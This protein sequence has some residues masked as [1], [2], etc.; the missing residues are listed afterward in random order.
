MSP[1]V[2]GSCASPPSVLNLGR[3]FFAPGVGF[4][5]SVVPAPPPLPPP[6]PPLSEGVVLCLPPPPVGVVGVVGELPE[7]PPV[8]LPLWSPLLR[9]VIGML[10][11]EP[12]AGPFVY[13]A[14]G[15]AL[16]PGAPGILSPVP[17]PPTGGGLSPTVRPL[18]GWTAPL[19]PGDRGASPPPTTSN[20]ESEASPPGAGGVL[21]AGEVLLPGDGLL[22]GKGTFPEV[23]ALGEVLLPGDGLLVGKGTFP[24]VPDLGE[25]VPLPGEGLLRAGEGLLCAGEGLLCA[26]EG[27]LRVVAVPEVPVVGVVGVTSSSPPSSSSSTSSFPFLVSGLLLTSRVFLAGAPFVA[28][29]LLEK[30][31]SF[32]SACVSY[33]CMI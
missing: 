33:A 24:E 3:S 21:R 8:S 10:F 16:V 15:V 18:L 4:P 28:P 6:L 25:V 9:P 22:V 12:L 26:G 5:G 13:P 19:L 23:P 17:A 7:E 27:L 32:T 14:G 30:P 2:L 1:K 11:D 31:L 20:G 29:S